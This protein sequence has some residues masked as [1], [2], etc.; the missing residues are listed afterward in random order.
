[1]HRPAELVA[2]TNPNE[3]NS[4]FRLSSTI[5]LSPQSGLTITWSSVPTYS[6]SRSEALED[7]FNVLSNPVP[8]GGTTTSYTKRST[9]GTGPYFYRILSSHNL[10]HG[11]S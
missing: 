1:M 10:H 7:G 8:S 4:V 11:Q 6:V 3:P 2:G 5:E 9:T